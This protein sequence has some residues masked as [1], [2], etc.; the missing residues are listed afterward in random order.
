MTLYLIIV[1]HIF[2]IY[3]SSCAG[4]CGGVKYICYIDKPSARFVLC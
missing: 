1:K 4:V 2:I 3:S